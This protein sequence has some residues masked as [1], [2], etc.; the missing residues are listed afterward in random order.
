MVCISKDQNNNI[1]GFDLE[2]RVVFTKGPQR[3]VAML[4]IANAFEIFLIHLHA[5]QRIT[6]FLSVIQSKAQLD[7]GIPDSLKGWLENKAIF[8]CGV[9]IKNDGM[10]LQRDFDVCI[11]GLI[12]TSHLARESTDMNFSRPGGVVSLAELSERIVKPTFCIT[13]Y[14]L[15]KVRDRWACHSPNKG[16]FDAVIGSPPVCPKVCLI[17][18]HSMCMLV[19]PSPKHWHYVSDNCHLLR[20]AS[21]TSCFKGKHQR[22]Q[23]RKRK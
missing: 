19:M 17:T 3:P 18:L 4:Q 11:D 5:I 8:K 9:N 10:K 13:L 2:W 12:E 14:S 15:F 21:K 23:Q 20:L 16:M 7:S 6:L 1:Y 22:V